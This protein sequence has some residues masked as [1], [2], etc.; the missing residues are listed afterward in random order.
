MKHL[1]FLALG[2]FSAASALAQ[3]LDVP[4][5]ETITVAKPVVLLQPVSVSS[6]QI[7]RILIDTSARQISFQLIG[8]NQTVSLEGAA[9]DAIAASFTQQFAQSIAPLIQARLCSEGVSSGQ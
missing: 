5:P 4:L 9:Y 6:V 8:G 2:F 1:C 7:S 3:P